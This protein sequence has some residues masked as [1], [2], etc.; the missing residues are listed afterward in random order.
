MPSESRGD[1]TFSGK[2]ASCDTAPDGSRSVGWSIGRLKAPD[3]D[4]VFA[5][6]IEGQ[7]VFPGFEVENRL[8]AA[9]A[10]AGLWPA[11]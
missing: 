11:Q 4:L 9:F 6:S 5:A 7:N 3:R 8:K 1:V 10:A 2:A